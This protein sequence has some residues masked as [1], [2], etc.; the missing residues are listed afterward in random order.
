MPM[1][2]TA[3]APTVDLATARAR[4]ELDRLAAHLGAEVDSFYTC[5]PPVNQVETWDGSSKWYEGNWGAVLF[6]TQIGWG[7][8]A[9]YGR[10]R[11]GQA[12]QV[13]DIDISPHPSGR[14]RLSVWLSGRV[15]RG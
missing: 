1:P 8:L 4:R 2:P 13:N 12:V 3:V 11:K 5:E 10:L 9:E 6:A 14:L 15:L 7:D